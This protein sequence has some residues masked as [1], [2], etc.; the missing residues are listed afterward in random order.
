MSAIPIRGAG[1]TDTLLGALGEQIAARGERYAL[2]VVG[3]SA[4]L[5]LALV[6][7]ATRDVDVVAIV[8]DG[9]LVSAEPFPPGLQDA[10]ALVAR[11]FGLPVQWLNPGP[12]SLMELGLP[13]GFFERAERRD[14]G[15]ALIVLFASRTDQIYLKL[16][17][18]VDQGAGKH[19]NDLRALDPSERELLDAAA[20]SRS[21]DPSAGYLSLLEAALEHL[22][23]KDD[24]TLSA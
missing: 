3:G 16:Y 7:R 11:D 9:E 2:A 14:Y 17:A 1:D 12:A 13:E 15:D 4:L 23:A 19:L 18:T 8:H 5:A 6:S 20:W 10:A 22:G 21:Q 24:G